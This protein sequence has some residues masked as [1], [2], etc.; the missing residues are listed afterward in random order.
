MQLKNTTQN[1]NENIAHCL[2]LSWFLQKTFD[3][4]KFLLEESPDLSVAQHLFVPQKDCIKASTLARFSFSCRVPT[5]GTCRKSPQTSGLILGNNHCHRHTCKCF[6]VFGIGK[7]VRQILLRLRLICAKKI[8]TRSN[9]LQALANLDKSSQTFYPHVWIF[10]G[11]LRFENMLPLGLHL[12]RKY[13]KY[14]SVNFQ[15][16]GYIKIF[17]SI[18]SG[19][20]L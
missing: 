5:I 7:H 16:Y 10:D 20:T 4:T 1:S 8:D 6:S 15:L 12:K 3:I 17:A 18:T 19:K 2:N 14:S 9:R 13:P 11:L